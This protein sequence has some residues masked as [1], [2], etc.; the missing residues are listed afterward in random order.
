MNTNLPTPRTD[1]MQRKMAEDLQVQTAT[2]VS[3]EFAR[4]L[5]RELITAKVHLAD[6]NKGARINALVNVE[7]TRKNAELKA[8]L[9]LSK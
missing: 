5:E 4:I 3:V 2:V 7:L 1:A 8:A 9:D 6:A